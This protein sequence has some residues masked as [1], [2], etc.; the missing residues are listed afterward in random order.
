MLA[1]QLS[2]LRSMAQ[3]AWLAWRLGYGRDRDR[4]LLVRL[5]KQNWSANKFG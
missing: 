5:E 1:N 3:H 2:Q 4:Y